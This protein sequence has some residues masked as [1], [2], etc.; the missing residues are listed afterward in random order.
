MAITLT[1]NGGAARRQATS[2]SAASGDRAA[3]RRAHG[4]AARASPTCSSSPTRPGPRT[5]S[6]ESTACRS[7]ST[8]RACLYLDGTELDFAREGLMRRASGSTT[9]TSRAPAAAARA[10]TSD[11]PV[12]RP[13]RRAPA[14]DALP[15]RVATARPG[16]ADDRLLAANHFAL[17]GLPR[18]FAS[19]PT[20]SSSATATLQPQCTPTA[21]PPPTTRERRLA[22]Q[23]SA[24][25]QRGLP[26]AEGPRRRGPS[27]C[28]SCTASI[29]TPGPTPRCR[30]S[31]SSEQLERREAPTQRRRRRRRP[32]RWTR[33]SRRSAPRPRRS[34]RGSRLLDARRRLD[35]GRMP[36]REL[37][38]LAKLQP[39]TSTPMA[40]VLDD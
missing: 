39:L 35:R 12:R 27:T 23:A 33:C 14:P 38:F 18:R 1:E 2:S 26:G 36:V 3:P 21:S 31:S 10:S 15:A 32:L 25:R 4:A 30:S 6:F 9:R 19:T 37:R 17:F 11:R 16:A 40:A 34:R 5:R 7:S 28:C 29:S 24:A 20:R 22:L 13:R 8:R